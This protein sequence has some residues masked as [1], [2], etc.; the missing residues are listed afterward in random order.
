MSCSSTSGPRPSGFTLIELLVVVSIIAILAGMLL[1]VIGIVRETAR[2]SQCGKNQSQILGAMVA[3][4][5]QEDTGWPDPRGASWKVPYVATGVVSATDAPR[6]TAGAFE[7]AAVKLAVANSM[8]RCPSAAVGGPNNNVKPSI[9]A[10]STDWGWSGSSV[11]AVSYAFDWSSPP[12][13]GSA[14]V[15]LADR[16]AKY[17]ADVAMACFGDAHVKKLKK[18][19]S[20]TSGGNRTMGVIQTSVTVFIEN[21][22]AKGAAG[23]DD[24]ASRVEPD[25]IYDDVGDVDTAAGGTADDVFKPGGGHPRRAFVK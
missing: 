6:F 19:P 3:Y 10:A 17:H 22:D 7:L 9:S 15:I 13:P 21:P 23:V 11:G 2:Q 1:P 14:R 12:D 18:H 25:N 5:S 16:D 4:A 8:F 20:A 24:D